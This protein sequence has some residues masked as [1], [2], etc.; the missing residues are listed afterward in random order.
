[1]VQQSAEDAA[2]AHAKASVASDY[3]T[4]IRD[5][6]PEALADLMQA[7]GGGW[8]DQLSYDLTPQ[9]REVDDFIFDI[10]YETE[11]GPVA[12]K[13]HFRSIE[14]VWK[15]VHIEHLA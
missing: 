7:A 11:A 8:R 4:V 1:M 3:T 2:H 6:T 13:Y 9:G 10:R 5:L 14:G 12:L 15:I